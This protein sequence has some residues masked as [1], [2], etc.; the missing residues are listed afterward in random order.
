MTPHDDPVGAPVPGW[1]PAGVPDG[2]P[3]RGRH[4]GL[5]RLAAGD[6]DP[7]FARLDPARNPRDWLYMPAGPFATAAAFGDWLGPLAA[8]DDPLFHVMTRAG[9]EAPF[10]V[11]ALLDIR[12]AT[13]VI[14]VGHVQVAPDFQRTT[15]FTEAMHLLARHVFALGYRRYE[16]KCDALNLRSRRA[17]H[18]LGFSYEGLFRQHM[19]VKGRNRDTRWFSIIDRDWPAIGRAHARWLD[20]GNF[21]AA[22]RQRQSL[23]SLTAP[24]VAC[25][26]PGLPAP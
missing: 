21:D 16:W 3:L 14:E 18:R 23:S 6:I 22:G 15:A 25:R 24:L 2:A 26:D 5:R 11:C 13:G 10:G 7:L 17:A 8:R 20:P 9:D 4:A 12:P 19:V 1:Q